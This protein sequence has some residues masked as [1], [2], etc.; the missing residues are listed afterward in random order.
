MIVTQPWIVTPL[1]NKCL[2]SSSRVPGLEVVLGMRAVEA[3][4]PASEL[5]LALRGTDGDQEE[6]EPRS[7]VI[8]KT[9]TQ[10][11][12]GAGR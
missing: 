1:L 12:G 2:S 5:F 9:V 11:I 10:S 8:R 4:G 3:L 6:N 7:R